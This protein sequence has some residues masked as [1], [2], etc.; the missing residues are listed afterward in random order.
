MKLKVGEIITIGETSI[1][2]IG[3]GNIWIEDTLDN[4]DSKNLVQ[5][6]MKFALDH[7]TAGQ[8]ELVVY[9]ENLSGIAAPFLSLNNSGEKL[10]TTIRSCRKFE[11]YLDHLHDHINGVLNVIGGRAKTLTEFRTDV[12]Y[13][14]EGY[15]LVVLSGDYDL[16]KEDVKNK[17]LT[18]LRVGPKAGVSFLVHSMTLLENN[19]VLKYFTLL[20]NLGPMII[21]NEGPFI[22]E[23]PI[24]HNQELIRTAEDISRA[25]SSTS[26]NS[27]S[28]TDVQPIDKLWKESSINGLTFSIG[29]YG[30]DIKDITLGD[31]LNQRHNILITGAVGQGKSNLI[32][33][34]LHSLCQR[35]S[36]DEL[37][38]YLL[39]FK[40][41]VS[42]QPFVPDSEGV[43]L[44]HAKALGLEADREYGLS[45][46]TYLIEV[47]KERMSIFKSFNVQN[48]KQYRTAFPKKIMPR[49]L[50][51]IDEF[52]LMFSEDD[53]NSTEIARLLMK[54]ARL[55]RAAGIHI[56]LSSQTI[57][58]NKAL[59]GTD[60]DGL[61]GQVPIRLALKN[62][63]SES[64][65]TLGSPNDAA[66]HLRSREA[67]VNLDYGNLASNMKTSI[68]FADDLVLAPLRK[69]WWNSAK[70]TG[71]LLSPS[72]FSGSKELS[73][74]FS[75]IS[76]EDNSNGA[77]VIMGNKVSVSSAKL[78]LPFEN[79]FG[80]NLIIFGNGPGIEILGNISISL[81]SSSQNSRF[82]IF[83]LM[84]KGEKEILN[85][86]T[87]VNIL[88]RYPGEVEWIDV[89]DFHRNF[90][91]FFSGFDMDSFGKVNTYFVI[92]GVERLRDIPD[93]LL[94]IMRRGPILGVHLLLWWS[95]PGEIDNK[96]GYNW[97]SYFD[98]KAIM[99]LDSQSARN[100]LGN[101]LLSWKPAN[102]R[103]L[104]WDR[105]EM[106]DPVGV[107]PYSKFSIDF[108]LK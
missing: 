24:P 15:K 89:D 40:E 103:M 47:Y 69:I 85:I 70:E 99:Q 49:I 7:T 94:E 55:F 59:M 87:L 45:V 46:L 78:I 108:E 77:S 25:V 51:V 35:Y 73:L 53:S 84:K 106:Q 38:L 32:Y 86:S 62:S 105:M 81:A 67:I 104:V 43:F 19:L 97:S 93:S 107:I 21:K 17:L 58:G 88:E 98:I 56:L 16:L 74:N 29:R 79:N 8:L 37:E 64:Y 22:G 83:N 23:F 63:I 102:N 9:D 100:I 10:L 4:Q 66:A 6:L 3:Q 80:R 101:P 42:L 90:E 44:P 75:D 39:D 33:M 71:R 52:Q 41:G 11:E 30:L 13:P 36:P 91:D 5:G 12:D 31:E 2:F 50:F 61:F 48:I 65:A 57:G 14:I 20:S 28:F 54:G 68:A 1:N 76:Q 82:F 34:I 60:A 18:L 95:Q 96:L 72:V 26:L 27:I 92:F